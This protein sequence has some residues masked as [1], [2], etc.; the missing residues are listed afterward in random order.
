MKYNVW[1]NVI[2]SQLTRFFWVYRFHF[3][4]HTMKQSTYE[5]FVEIDKTTTFLKMQAIVIFEQHVTITLHVTPLSPS[6]PLHCHLP[7]L[8][9]PLHTIWLH[10]NFIESPCA[11][12]LNQFSLYIEE[13]EVT[14]VESFSCPPEGVNCPM[15]LTYVHYKHRLKLDIKYTLFVFP[16]ILT[17]VFR[18]L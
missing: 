12:Y 16:P 6:I 9:V 8:I 18:P 7:L 3:L 14:S 13:I 4:Q 15:S 1:R 2:P 5:V 10:V 17:H 11:Y